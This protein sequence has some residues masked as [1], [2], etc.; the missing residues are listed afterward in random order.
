MSSYKSLILFVK[1]AQA[2]GRATLEIFQDI[3]LYDFIFLVP[4]GDAT[5]RCRSI[6]LLS[7]DP[8]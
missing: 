5:V 6:G 8:H 4:V 3:D 7:V 1:L 2:V